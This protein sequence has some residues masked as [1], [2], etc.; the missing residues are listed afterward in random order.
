MNQTRLWLFV[1]V[2]AV[3]ALLTGSVY[4]AYAY[5]STA[6]GSIALKK[7]DGTNVGATDAYSPKAT[8]SRACH[9]GEGGLTEEFAGHNYGSGDKFSTHVQGV[10]AGSGSNSTVYWEASQTKSFE[11][12]VSAGKHM[13][14]GRNEDYTNTYRAKYGDPYFTSSGGMYGKY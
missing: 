4:T 3:A 11:H 5:H 12:G 14:E 8:C 9:I 10:L 6:G 7:A 13:N 2:L 1:T